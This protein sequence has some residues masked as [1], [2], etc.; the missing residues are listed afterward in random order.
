V[1]VELSLEQPEAV[2]EAIAAL[3]STPV[4]EPDPWW[5]AGLDEAL[6][7]AE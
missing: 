1:G 5:R 7:E 4:R 6:A 2:A 3:V